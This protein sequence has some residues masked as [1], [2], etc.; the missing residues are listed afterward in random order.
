MGMTRAERVALHTNQKRMQL[1]GNMPNEKSLV[2]GKPQ[3]RETFKGLYQYVKYNNEVYSQLLTKDT[4][5]LQEEINDTVNNITVNEITISGTLD[6]SS[7]GTGLATIADGAVML[8]SGTSAVTP[9]AVTTNGAILI[10]DGTTDPTTYNAFS[11]STGTLNVGAGGTGQTTVTDFK[12]VLDDETWTFANNVTATGRAIVDDTTEATSTTDGSLQTDGGLSVVKSVVIG[13]DL[14]LLS[15]SC[16]INVGSTSKF[17]LTDQ[18]SNNCLMAT[19]D[20]RLAFGDAGEYIYGDGTD[21]KIISSGDV[22]MTATLFDVTGAITASGIIKT[23][24]ATEATS[25]TDGS[26]QTDGGLS[27][28]KDAIFGNDVK[29]L[30]DASVFSMGVGSDFTITHDGSTGATITSSGA[31][32]VDSTA[33]TLTLDGH[34]GVTV[35]SSNSGDI[36]LDSVADVVLDAAG[37][38]FEFKDATVGKLT[39]DVDGTAGDIDINLV[40]DGDDLVFNQRDDSEVLRL[41]DGSLVVIRNSYITDHSINNKPASNGRHFATGDADYEQNYCW[42]GLYDQ[43]AAA[44]EHDADYGDWGE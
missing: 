13:D 14:D 4:R 24:D 28:V 7:G 3:Y 10:G 12:N 34:T 26:L 11:S 43:I 30:T 19:A 17:T 38:N 15:D 20:H 31:L 16:I 40:A 42:V 22:D 2:E 44:S 9:L 5:T 32:I 21:M 37:G 1:S 23:D 27:V 39:I 6:V 8:G 41:T 36:L 25:T 29:L 18:S 35:Q 33:S